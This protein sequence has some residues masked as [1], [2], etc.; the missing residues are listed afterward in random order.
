MRSLIPYRDEYGLLCRQE[1]VG[2]KVVLG[3]GDSLHKTSHLFTYL[4]F[5]DEIDNIALFK[6]ILQSKAACEIADGILVRHPDPTKWY[7][8][9]NTTSRDQLRAAIVA[10][11]V[12]NVAPHTLGRVFRRHLKRGLLFAW[13]T[14]INGSYPTLEEYNKNNPQKPWDGYKWKLPD[15]TLFKVWASYIRGFRCKP[16]YPLLYLFDLESL[17]GAVTNKYSSNADQ[18]NNLGE[19]LLAKHSMDTFVMKLARR[20]AK[21]Y[22]YKRLEEYFTNEGEPPLHEYAKP[23]VD[24][25]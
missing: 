11:S 3:G 20:I 22:L 15:L 24:N 18:A 1:R 21:P 4:Y 6:S 7:S 9:P 2:D 8:N 12:G 13:N 10:L 16:L 23:L 17:V 5:N 14:R 25:L 19:Y